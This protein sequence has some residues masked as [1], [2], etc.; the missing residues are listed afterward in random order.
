METGGRLM[1]LG[2]LSLLLAL[3]GALYTHVAASRWDRMSAV[4]GLSAATDEM[5][6]RPPNPDNFKTANEKFGA[7][8]TA[9]YVVGGVGLLF[10]GIGWAVAAPRQN[11]GSKRDVLDK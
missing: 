9:T 8:R 7:Y 2:G 11:G 4:R 6:G 1:V 5:S 10:L 3:A